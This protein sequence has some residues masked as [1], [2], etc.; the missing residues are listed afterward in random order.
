MYLPV[1]GVYALY[2]C[3]ACSLV[4][5][6]PRP[7]LAAIGHVNDQKYD[8]DDE[9]ESRLAMYEKEYTRAKNHVLEIQ[10][11]CRIRDIARHRM[12]LWHMCKSCK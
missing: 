8:S 7:R 5:T 3:T 1:D 11:I 10:K 12:Q 6:H 2:I 4:F 9:K